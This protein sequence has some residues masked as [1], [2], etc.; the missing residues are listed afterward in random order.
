MILTVLITFPDRWQNMTCYNRS[1]IASSYTFTAAWKKHLF[2]CNMTM[3]HQVLGSQQF[4]TTML[5]QNVRNKTTSDAASFHRRMKN[6]GQNLNFSG[7]HKLEHFNADILLMWNGA[8]C[9]LVVSYDIF[10]QCI[11]PIFEGKSLLG[12]L[13]P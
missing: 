6:S 13:D 4:K 2:C 3:H 8:L 5:F 1:Q 12:L 11:C 9:R 7:S 10:R